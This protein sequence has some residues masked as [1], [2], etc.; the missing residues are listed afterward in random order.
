MNALADDEYK[1]EEDEYE[2]V[3]TGEPRQIKSDTV[4]K[5]L[6]GRYPFPIEQDDFED[7]TLSDY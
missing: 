4:K 1:L 2:V 3:D 5:K 6:D 7:Y